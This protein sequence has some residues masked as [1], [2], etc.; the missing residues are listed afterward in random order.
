[1][2]I[3]TNPGGAK[4]WQRRDR[5]KQLLVWGGWMAGIVVF[6]Y[7]WE[8]ISKVTTW[9]FV[10][11]AP[12]I[13]DDILSRAMPPR[14]S[15][16]EELWWP[17]WDTINIATIGTVVSIMIAIPI[18]FLAARNTTPSKYFVR[19]IALFIIVGSRSIN[20]IIWALLL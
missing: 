1:M 18:A 3:S 16:M 13:A 9:M 10:L 7:C 17:V 4:I 20:S 15:Y 12:L 8:Q 6:M 2:A 11:D 14:W 5:N 19:P